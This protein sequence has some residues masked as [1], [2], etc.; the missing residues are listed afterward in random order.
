MGNL[1]VLHNLQCFII[2]PL[3]G[4]HIQLSD[5][6]G[7]VPGGDTNTL[8]VASEMASSFKICQI[9]Y[10]EPAVATPSK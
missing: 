4:L 5:R 7:S 2:L 3:S 1:R 9:H 8:G 10:A 6:S